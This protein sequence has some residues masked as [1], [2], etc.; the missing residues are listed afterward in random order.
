MTKKEPGESRRRPARPG[1]SGHCLQARPDKPGGEQ[2]AVA[3]RANTL[4]ASAL[5]RG[6]IVSRRSLAIRKAVVIW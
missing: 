2:D 4:A 5:A 3:A 1:K 6:R